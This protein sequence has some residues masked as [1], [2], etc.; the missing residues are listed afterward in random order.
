[1]AG[2]VP[3]RPPVRPRRAGGTGPAVETEGLVVVL[4]GI[5]ALDGVD[6]RVPLGSIHGVVGA[7]GAGKTTLLRVL[8]GVLRPDGGSARVL[9]S[10]VGT[11]ADALGARVGR[12]GWSAGFDEQRTGG[13]NLLQLARLLGYSRAAAL[14]RTDQLLAGFGLTAAAGQPIATYSAAARRRLDLAASIV[15]RPELVLLDEPTADLDPHCRAEVAAVLRA[16]VRA[17]TTVLLATRDLDEAGRLAD[18]LSVLASG[19]V[20]AE[21]TASEVRARASALRSGGGAGPSPAS[22]PTGPAA[23][24]RSRPSR[25]CPGA[26]GPPAGS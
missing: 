23:P 9:G 26:P 24:A 7:G 15:V 17:G 18:R 22:A 11:E 19:R 4:G 10:D 25:R 12:T 1:M 2:D 21:G 14:L 20:V 3:R 13:A 5:R 8:A 16:L 6:L